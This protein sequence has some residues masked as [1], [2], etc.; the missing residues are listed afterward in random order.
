MMALE[1]RAGIVAVVFTVLVTAVETAAPLVTRDAIDIAT[2]SRTQ[3]LPTRLL[4]EF[5]PL[6]AVIVVLLVLAVVRFV[7]QFGRRW[8]AGRMS[9]GVQHRLR[10]KVLDRLLGTSG[11]AQDQVSTGQVASRAISDLATI[12]GITAVLPLAT[13]N[14]LRVVAMI[15]VMLW[16]SPWLALVALASVPLIVAGASLSRKSLFAATWTAQQKA[17]DLATRVEETVTGVRVVKAFA[18]EQREVDAV[19]NL[20]REVYAHRMRAAKVTARFQP[21]LDQLPLVTLVVNVA[22]GGWLTLQGQISVGTFVAFT[23]Y[24]TAMT[25]ATRMLAGVAV[26]VQ[27]ALSSVA[28]IHDV[29]DLPQAVPAAGAAADGAP[30]APVPA[31]PLGVRVEDVSFSTRGTTVLSGVNWSVPA[32]GHIALI[33]P[34]GAG[35]TMLVQLLGGFY[36]PEAGRIVLTGAASSPE[37]TPVEVNVSDLDPRALRE[38]VVCVFDEAWLLSDTVR[39]NITLGGDYSEEEVR[40]ATDLAQATEFIE[41]LEHGFDTVLGERG[42]TL[43]GGQRQRVALARAILRRPR[44]LVLDDATSAIDAATEAAII[45]GMAEQLRDVTIVSVAHRESTLRAADTLVVLDGGRVTAAGPVASMAA[46][47][48]VATLMALA[49]TPAGEPVPFDEGQTPAWEELWPPH[50]AGDAGQGGPSA[51]QMRRAAARNSARSAG[52]HPHGA[53]GPG[54]PAAIS[55]TPELMRRAAAL[56]PAQESPGVDAARWRDAVGGLRPWAM[57]RDVRGL[58]AAV[59]A[60]LIVGVACDLAFPALMR[61]AIDHGIAARSAATLW[62]I[63]A[64]G[65]VVVLASWAAAAWQTVLAA[66]TG[67]RLLFALRVRSYA[68]VQRLSLSYFERTRAGSILTR[69]TTDIDSLTSFLQTGL[70]QAIVSV[71]TLGGVTAILVTTDWRLAL[72]ALGVVPVVAVATIVFRRISSRLYGQARRDISAVNAD[73]QESVTGLRS[74]QAYRAE[75]HMAD[76]FAHAALRYRT[77]RLHSQKVIAIYFTGVSFLSL[78][79]EAVVLGVGATMVQQGTLSAGVLVSAVLYLGLLLSPIQVLSQVFDSYQQA[80]VSLGRIADLLATEPHVPDTGTRDTEDARRAAQGTIELRDV[81]FAYAPAGSSNPAEHLPPSTA[82]LH[83]ISVR[84]APGSTVAVVGP[85]GAGKSTIMKLLARFYDP[86]SGSV[87][88]GE[89]TGGTDTTDIRD[90]ELHAWRRTLGLVPQEAHLF[91]GTVADNI[92]YGRPTATAEEIT[93]A[94]RRVGALTAISRIPGGFRHP[95]GERGQGLSSGQRQLIALARAELVE[96]ALLLLDEATATVDPA[97]ET[98]ILNASG[99][100]TQRR[101]S[102]VVA[103]RL[104]TAARADRI[105]VVDGGRI[106]EDGTHAELLARGGTYRRMWEAKTQENTPGVAATPPPITPER[107]QDETFTP[108]SR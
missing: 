95:I 40:R 104:A 83:N 103:H 105:L 5:S 24:L 73:F 15:G 94:A 13:G 11:R 75:P 19:E 6:A 10:L 8:F 86:G 1:R 50:T 65:L 51:S 76:R 43:S 80:Q 97:T 69:M 4:P 55:A 74:I 7:C 89:T 37:G 98:T 63:S 28:R 36:P 81:T 90:F 84:I 12:Q 66:R 70:A 3:A 100:A 20:S 88:A 22:L 68:H 108:G 82:A 79:T 54:M 29:L 96:P 72:V 26:R 32:G 107:E 64:A 33:G 44:V 62:W 93:D 91:S 2:G 41:G 92:A 61:L 59:V 101:T 38:A 99:R 18:Q 87:R 85:T 102:V 53:G 52:G 56:P 34:P 27:L 9:I 67:E 42:L 16:L 39:A 23:T 106:T 35:K 57:L 78:A 45:R 31:G 58:I 14:A 21:A 49:P 77:T 17:A 60:L 47:P 25:S 46:D 48:Q 71:G 30:A